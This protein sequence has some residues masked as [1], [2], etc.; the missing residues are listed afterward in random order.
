MEKKGGDM[1]DTTFPLFPPGN[2]TDIDAK[3]GGAFTLCEAGAFAGG[4]EFVGGHFESLGVGLAHIQ[5]QP[6]RGNQ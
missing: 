6:L 1:W 3:Q 4:F 5:R 2:G